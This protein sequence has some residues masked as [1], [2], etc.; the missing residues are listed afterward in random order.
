V[1]EA[2]F[3]VAVELEIVELGNVDLNK[4][5]ELLEELE[6]EVD[7]FNELLSLVVDALVAVDVLVVVNMLVVIDVLVPVD[8]LIGYL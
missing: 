4:K 7:D 5:E 8:V 6:L 2:L 1:V 3:D